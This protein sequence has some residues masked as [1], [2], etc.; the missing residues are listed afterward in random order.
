MSIRINA[1]RSICSIVAIGFLVGCTSTTPP[2]LP[3]GNPADPQ[4]RVQAKPPNNLLAHDETTLAIQAELSQTEQAAKSAENMQQMGQGDMPGMQHGDTKMEGHKD[5]SNATDVDSEKKAVADEMEKTSD[6][7]KKT[8]ETMKE[9]SEQKESKNFY[10]TCRMH[11]QIHR[12]KPGNCPIC[13]M[14]LIKKEGSPPK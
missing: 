9:K 3:A 2:P 1:K 10:Y 12:D 4:V 5:M 7:M 11:P 6:E 14:T 8:S 13:G